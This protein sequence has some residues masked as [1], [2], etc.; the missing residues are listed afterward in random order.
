MAFKWADAVIG[1]SSAVISYRFLKSAFGRADEA[2]TKLEGKRGG[3]CP[4]DGSIPCRMYEAGS[5]E[6][7][8]KRIGELIRKGSLDPQVRRLAV[9]S[10]SKQCPGDK[11][12]TPSRDAKKEITRVLDDLKNPSSELAQ[13]M[14]EIDGMLYATKKNVRYVSDARLSDQFQSAPRTL[15]DFHGGDCDDH[16][17]ALGA[18]LM[19]LGYPCQQRIYTLKGQSEPGHIA[20]R[21]SPDKRGEKYITLDASV[22]AVKLNGRKVPIFAGW[23]AAV[24]SNMIKSFKDYPV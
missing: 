20:L 14:A 17:I 15:F 21:V 16:V 4:G 12:C 23:D 2:L 8:A 10:V 3:A 1:I 9:R 11:F 6:S 19:A 22:D 13:G 24:H 18:L 5:I 7:R